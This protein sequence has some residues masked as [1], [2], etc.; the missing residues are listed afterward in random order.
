[1]PV[2]TEAPPDVDHADKLRFE[3]NEDGAPSLMKEFVLFDRGFDCSNNGH[4]PSADMLQLFTS[5]LGISA[6][7]DSSKHL[8]HLLTILK[9]VLFL[10]DVW[11]H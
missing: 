4:R 5:L 7:W 1:M 8:Q 3:R 6:Y 2:S 11:G 10:V 9:D